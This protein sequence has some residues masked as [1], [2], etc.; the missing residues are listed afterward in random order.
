MVINALCDYYDL[1]LE[2]D[3]TQISAYG[4]QPTKAAYCA[5][6]QKNGKLFAINS[7]ID[8][9]KKPKDFILPKSMK[10][11]GIAASFIC[12]NFAYIFGVDTDS[13]GKQILDKRK[14]ETAKALHISL[15]KVAQSEA[16]LAIK[17]FFEM[18]DIE[19]AWENE[20]IL[21]HHGKKGFVGNI[22][23][24]IVGEEK[25]LHDEKEVLDLWLQENEKKDAQ[26]GEHSGVCAIT[27][28][29]SNIVRLHSQLNGVKGASTMGASLIC[30]NKSA[31]NSYNLEQSYNSSVSKMAMFKYTTALQ[32]LLNNKTHKIFI[33]DDTTVFWSDGVSGEEENFFKEALNGKEKDDEQSVMVRDVLKNGVAGITSKDLDLNSKFYILGLA[34]NAG[35]I[36]VRYFYKDTFGVFISRVLKH[37]KDMEIC[38]GKLDFGQLPISSLLYATISPKSKDKNINPLLG[39][40]VVRAILTGQPYPQILYS[41]VLVR[42]KTEATITHARASIIKGYLIRNKKEEIGMYLNDES[43]NTAYV[44]GRTF[45]ILEHIQKN[46]SGGELNSTIKD[47]FFGAACCNPAQV[48]P[49]LMQLTAHHLAKLEGNYWNLELSKCINK[50][51]IDTFPKS[52]DTDSQGRFILG[53]YQQ[54]QKNY[55]KNTKNTEE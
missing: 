53:Y 37:Y 6:I 13:S 15:L 7:L 16:A 22:V 44:L 42:C 28:K 12:D 4:Y 52:F 21:A 20:H 14:F 54:V 31:D 38:G 8:E 39:G 32:Y 35:R 43:T 55:T 25:F 26:E 2:H 24:K 3:S 36:S 5:V 1:I 18:W 34:P 47:K 50:L 9:A 17:N 29:R 46:A 48:F 41:Q 10:K 49:K 45:A 27:G 40:A 19:T 30:F 11:S 23:F 51:E 33:G